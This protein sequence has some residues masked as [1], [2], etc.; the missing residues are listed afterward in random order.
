MVG[1]IFLIK[2]RL[3]DAHIWKFTFWSSFLIQGCSGHTVWDFGCWAIC[4]FNKGAEL[5]FFISVNLDSLVLH[6]LSVGGIC[7]TRPS[8]PLIDNLNQSKRI[9]SPRHVKRAPLYDRFMAGG[10]CKIDN[11]LKNSHFLEGQAGRALRM[12]RPTVGHALAQHSPWHGPCRGPLTSR[13][14]HLTFLSSP[15]VTYSQTSLQLEFLP[16]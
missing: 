11:F 6:M 14:A 3:F 10:G 4:A 13:P 15:L 12:S 7:R 8:G 5:K 9:S 1:L 16:S 2:K